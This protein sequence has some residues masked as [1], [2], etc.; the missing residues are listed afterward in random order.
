MAVDTASGGVKTLV[1]TTTAQPAK[2]ANN[3]NVAVFLV[4]SNQ[5]STPKILLCPSDNGSSKVAATNFNVGQ[6]ST[7]NVSYFVNGD[8]VESDPQMVLSG[9]QNVCVSSAPTKMLPSQQ[10]S[11]FIANAAFTTGDL[12][13]G[14]G[15]CAMSDGSV[16]SVSS[17]G[18]RTLLLNSTNNVTVQWFNF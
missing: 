17:S 12:H 5:L 4:M 18:F 9:D 13:Q 15:N 6:F 11:G 2:T 7:N 3:G 14:S 1:A 16:Q 10:L 8:A